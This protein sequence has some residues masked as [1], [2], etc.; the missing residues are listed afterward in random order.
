MSEKDLHRNSSAEIEPAEVEVGHRHRKDGSN[1]L[2][3]AQ[4]GVDQNDDERSMYVG[5]G[6]MSKDTTDDGWKESVW[7]ED[8]ISSRNASQKNRI[9]DKERQEMPLSRDELGDDDYYF[10][11]EEEEVSGGVYL[12]VVG[13]VFV[14][15]LILIGLVTWMV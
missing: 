13:G 15:T 6:L 11:T 1:Q 5:L 14:T 12:A 10:L 4:E 9:K 3:Q 7:Q 8:R 2:R